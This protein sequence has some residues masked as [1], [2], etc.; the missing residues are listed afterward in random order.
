MEIIK[1]KNDLLKVNNKNKTK[2]NYYI[3][4]YQNNILIYYK[5]LI[6]FSIIFYYIINL[7]KE[8]KIFNNTSKIIL[9]INGTGN[10]KILS[11]DNKAPDSILVKIFKIKIIINKI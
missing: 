9:K 4:L 1:L 2:L 7:S 11:N 6:Y 5:I 8:Q 10:Q 3:L